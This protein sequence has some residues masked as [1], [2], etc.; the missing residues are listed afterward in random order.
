MDEEVER[1]VVPSTPS[2]TET[3]GVSALCVCMHVCP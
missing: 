3:S 1:S 2:W